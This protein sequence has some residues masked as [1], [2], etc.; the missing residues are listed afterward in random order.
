VIGQSTVR[1]GGVERVTGAQK[2][3][4]DIRLD[5]PLHVKLVHLDCARAGI[6][7]IDTSAARCVEGVRCIL[8][9]ADL[10]QPVPR[11]GPAYADRPVL[12]VNETKFFGEP[13]AAVAAE[14]RDAAETAAAMV[15]VAYEERAAVLTIDAA[16]DPASPLVQAPELRPN[17]A[18]ANSNTLNEW[19]FGWGDVGSAAA[20]LVIE[21]EYTFPMVTHFA[22]EPHAFL[23]A[24]D[25]NGVTVW[26]P[27]QHPYVLQRVVASA[28]G[29][30]ISRVRIIAPDSGGGFGGK[31]WPKFEPLMALLALK[32]GRPVRL[33]LTL[34][35]TFQAVR[36]SSARVRI[37]TGFESSGRIA[38]QD[39]DADFL[40]GAYA[41]IG[42]RVVSKA[43]YAACGPY[44]TPHSRVVARAL[45][46]IPLRARPF[47][48]SEPHKPLGRS[49]RSW[50][51][52]RD[53]W[54]STGW[55]S[56]A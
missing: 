49:S 35:E 12:A 42:A 36:R 28:L 41:D 48:A 53:D 17:D 31:G 34:E 39:I 14:T 32:T 13:V 21:N 29:W 16:L 50:T 19:R 38:F 20:D 7:S 45:L 43:S 55:K 10:P 54:A 18:Y 40:L 11:F 5:H 26:S 3:A 9:G 8:T 24:P 30:P 46:P 33:V 4:A 2:Y 56:G 6:Q 37:R 22:I 27:V 15:R 47:E 51:K 44:R 23:A 1:V 52:R 25:A